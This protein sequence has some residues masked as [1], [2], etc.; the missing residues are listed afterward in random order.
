MCGAVKVFAAAL[1][2]TMANGKSV[3]TH[4]FGGDGKGRGEGNGM[5]KDSKRDLDDE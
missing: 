2:A 5:G 4:M 1:F 3:K